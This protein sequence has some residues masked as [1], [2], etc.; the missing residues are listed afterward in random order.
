MA[1]TEPFDR[2]RPIGAAFNALLVT[3]VDELG[4]NYV[5]LATSILALISSGG[6][7][8]LGAMAEVSAIEEQ[9]PN[10]LTQLRGRLA[11][12]EGEVLQLKARPIPSMDPESVFENAT[13]GFLVYDSEFHFTYSNRD[14][15][16]LLGK[17]KS[18]LVGKSQWEVFPETIGTEI[19]RQYRRVMTERVAIIFDSLYEPLKTWL[20]F[21]VSPSTMALGLASR[22]HGAPAGRDAT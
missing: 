5:V 17:P 20:E 8:R 22:R 1:A 6:G 21:R 14:V 9:S 12:L 16:R 15:E 2:R 4:V 10:G 13:D 19:E 3:D 11:D 18:E 7:R